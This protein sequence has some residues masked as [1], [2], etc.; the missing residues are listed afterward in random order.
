MGVSFDV[1]A[2]V[3]RMWGGTSVPMPMINMCTSIFDQ[4][5]IE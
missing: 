5:N 1:D 4:M 3:Q 2:A